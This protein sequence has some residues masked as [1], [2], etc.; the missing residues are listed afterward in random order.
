MNT[1]RSFWYQGCVLSGNRK[2]KSAALVKLLTQTIKKTKTKQQHRHD[3]LEKGKAE[4]DD[5]ELHR[6]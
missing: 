6:K 2:A 3:K 5:S 4:K 1:I